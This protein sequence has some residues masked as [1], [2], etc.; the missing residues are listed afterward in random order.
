MGKNTFI[1][2][3]IIFLISGCF[4]TIQGIQGIIRINHL[5]GSKHLET[6]FITRV[7]NYSRSTDKNVYFVLD[8]DIEQEYRINFFKLLFY[9]NPGDKVKVIFNDRRD[10]WIIPEYI[11]G[12]RLHYISMVI[13]SGLFWVGSII[14][15]LFIIRRSY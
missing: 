7:I 11:N 13:G 2:V 3:V 12:S 15:V 1:F 5:S 10:F 6:G 14:I 9:G 4:L 8:S